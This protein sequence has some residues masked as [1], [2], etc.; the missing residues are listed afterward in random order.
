MLCKR[1]H[2]VGNK[3]TDR[4]KKTRGRAEHPTGDANQVTDKTDG[5]SFFLGVGLCEESENRIPTDCVQWWLQCMHTEW[6]ELFVQY[7]SFR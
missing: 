6:A 5:L 1:E 2:C 4:G 3:P 7:C